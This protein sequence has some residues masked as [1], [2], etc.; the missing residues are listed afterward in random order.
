MPS[1]YS[2]DLRIELMANGDSL[3]S[4]FMGMEEDA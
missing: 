4:K 3:N 1:T 2:P